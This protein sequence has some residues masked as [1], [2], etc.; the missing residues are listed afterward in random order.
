MKARMDNNMIF[1]NAE[2]PKKL[3]DI[4][5]ILDEVAW[6][7]FGAGIKSGTVGP[8][9]VFDIAAQAALIKKYLSDYVDGLEEKFE[10][11]GVDFFGDESAQGQRRRLKME[12]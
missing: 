8:E 11:F 2:T 12:R 6:M 9:H 10:S 4:L 7:E 3:A 1:N 5:R